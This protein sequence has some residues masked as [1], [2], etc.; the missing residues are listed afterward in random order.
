[1]GLRNTELEYGALAKWLHWLVAIGLF[2]LL[3]LGLQ[4]AD[5]E[6]SPERSEIRELHASIAV[7]VFTLMSVRLV[8]RWSSTVP[9]HPADTPG[10][11]RSAASLV[12]G[13]L[14]I[15]VFAQLISGAMTVATNGDPLPFFGLFSIPLPVAA[16]DEGHE[17]W[18]EIH[19][20]AWIAVVTLVLIHVLGAL[21]NHFVKKNT[22][23]RR[24]TVGLRVGGA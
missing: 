2:T 23:M 7:C 19:E 18:E 13:G 22:V 16:S 15:A 6:R 9:A 8:W 12:H 20:I 10:W 17:F 4:Q 24:M 1:M 14:Y 5:M 3:W 21:Y 11:Q